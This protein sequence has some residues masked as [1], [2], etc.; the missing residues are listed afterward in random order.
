VILIWLG[1][2]QVGL[3]TQGFERLDLKPGEQAP[4]ADEVPQEEISPAEQNEEQE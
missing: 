1:I 4:Q 3:L 2:A